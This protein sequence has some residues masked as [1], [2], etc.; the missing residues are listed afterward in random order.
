VS[1]GGA[2]V[3]FSANG[4]CVTVVPASQLT[5]V[6]NNLKTMNWIRLGSWIM[7][8]KSNRQHC[9]HPSSQMTQELSLPAINS[10]SIY[11]AFFLIC[12]A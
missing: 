5:T 1:A 10:E 4:S 3:S 8:F 7:A 6:K 11:N 9:D 2:V 12:I